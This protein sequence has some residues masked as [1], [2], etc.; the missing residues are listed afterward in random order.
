[1]NFSNEKL[2][3]SLTEAT[4]IM[5]SYVSYKDCYFKNGRKVKFNLEVGS[6]VGGNKFSL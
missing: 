2:V 6:V 3:S 1:M 4:P 5:N